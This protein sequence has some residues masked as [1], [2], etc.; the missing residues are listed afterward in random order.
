MLSRYPTLQRLHEEL[1]GLAEPQADPR[2]G[3]RRTFRI[4]TTRDLMRCE[5]PGAGSF[6]LTDAQR[7]VVAV[8]LDAYLNSRN[9]DVQET[10]LLSAA[11]SQS[12]KLRLL[13]L[14]LARHVDPLYQLV[15]VTSCSPIYHDRYRPSRRYILTRNDLDESLTH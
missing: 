1:S 14:L 6:W 2:P 13:V 7:K 9:P 10:A 11:G 12:R 5:W 3:K 15:S 4:S 8:L